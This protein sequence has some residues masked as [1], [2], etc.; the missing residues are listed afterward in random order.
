M[1]FGSLWIPVVVSTVAVFIVSSIIHMLLRYHKLDY[2]Q[3]PNEDA[4]AEVFRK[5]SVAPG[6]YF[7]PHC[8]DAKQMKDPATV[9]KF[10]D[11]PVGL[12]TLMRTGPPNLGKHLIQWALLSFF[13]SFTAAYVARHALTY[14]AAG[15]TVTR[16]TGTVAFAA[17]GLGS[18]Q[19][20]IWKGVPWSNTLRSLVD[21]IVYAVVTGL[22]FCLLWPASGS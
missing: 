13:I 4:V 14:G 20:S 15:L 21:A 7:I 9:K 22:I 16:I 8:V 10:T 1:P 5:S 2:K 12:F 11:G 3:L 17:Y 19:E 18:I 6:C